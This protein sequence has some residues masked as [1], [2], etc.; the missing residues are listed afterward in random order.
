MKAMIFAAG[1]G[2]RLRPLT[3]TIPKAMVKVGGKPMLQIVLDRLYDAGIKDVIVNVHYLPEIIIGFIKEYDR[4][5]MSISISDESGEILETGGGLLKAKDFFDD[6]QPFLLANADVLTDIDIPSFVSAHNKMGGISTL[7]VRNR[8]SQRKLLFDDEMRLKGRAELEGE[9]T[10]AFSGYHIINPEIFNYITRTGK[11][12][13]TDW[14]LDICDEQPI[15]AYLH[16]ND[17][18]ID[19]GTREK[20]AL[21]EQV[22]RA[23][24]S[25]F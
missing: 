12:S 24:I 14:Y 6:N 1:L 15:Y 13:I 20:L 8:T 2:T 10:F 17:I 25:N 3:D 4:G 9:N 11:F 18:W 21:A 16:Q 22:Y 19:I 5:G 23:H 7:A